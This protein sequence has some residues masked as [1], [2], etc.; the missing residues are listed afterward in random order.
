MA[1]EDS[2]IVNAEDATPSEARS[3]VE[4][5][6]RWHLVSAVT[7]LILSVI[8][9]AIAAL[10]LVFP[11]F[12]ARIAYLSYGRV[13]AVA[14]HL[15]LYGWLALGFLAAV[16][17]VLPRISGREVKGASLA[18][19][20]LLLI[21]ISVASGAAEIV[22][23][24]GD[25]QPYLAA[26][27]IAELLFLAGL[28]LSAVTVT[29][30]VA[31]DVGQLVPAQWYLLGSSWWAVLLIAFSLIPGLPGA[32]G[33]MQV[34][35]LR[36]GLAGFWFAAAG[37]AFLYYLVPKLTGQTSFEGTPLSALGFWS[38]AFV[39]AATAP[40]LYIYGP[41]PGWLQSIGVAFSIALFVPV[42]LIARDLSVLMRGR[43]KLI[44]DRV[45]LA[46]ASVGM[47]LFV[48][49]PVHNLVQALR[50]SSSIVGLTEW[51]AAGDLLLFGGAF[52]FWLFAFA[53]YATGAGSNRRGLATW[54]LVLSVTG[55]AVA[56][57]AM[58]TAGAATGLTWAAGANAAEPTSFGEGWSVISKM[59]VPFLSFRAAGLVIFGL[60]QLLFGAAILTAPW[61]VSSSAPHVDDEAFDLQLTGRGA[62]ISCPALR[63]GI[64][65][66]FAVAAVVMVLVPALDASVTT[67]TIIADTV[68]SYPDGS[69]VAA[70]RDVYIREGCVACHTQSVRPIV[71]DVGLGAVGVAGDY[72][73]EAPALIG[74][75]RLGP[76]LMRVGN[77]I[78]DPGALGPH[79]DDPRAERPWSIMPSYRYLTQGDLDAL[80]EYL[81]SLR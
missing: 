18:P 11:D 59:L 30:T 8:V 3:G 66:A 17:F 57:G 62:T 31:Q 54:H 35:F 74:I 7:F 4:G 70:G 52:T 28:I 27:L 78:E 34:G 15:F 14:T 13:S 10:Q 24:L 67:G 38:L 39:W 77:R 49:V 21:V 65:A 40:V 58:W 29:R 26:P 42:A 25:G 19:I 68:R 32:A 36:A 33:A 16:Y 47:L 50:T 53:Y 5:I 6:V 51:T 23:G 69:V 60:S 73:N 64:V 46:F 79:L 44:D 12:G 56:I 45:A 22:A 37:L 76:D 71:P 2:E 81:L 55:L 43:A 48:L 80:S 72:V 41:I 1:T 63:G 9:G 61:R 75:G 20:S